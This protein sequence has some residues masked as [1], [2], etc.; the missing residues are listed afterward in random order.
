M[1]KIS[2][3]KQIQKEESQYE[4]Q[5]RFGALTFSHAISVAI[6]Y[7]SEPNDAAV[8]ELLGIFS[9]LVSA[10]LTSEIGMPK[11]SAAIWATFV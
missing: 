4:S 7:K 2:E 5:G 9:V 3:H 10:I 1:H 6:P 8:G 11:T